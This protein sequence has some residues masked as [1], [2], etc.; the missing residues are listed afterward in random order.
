MRNNRVRAR[1]ARK[2]S[3]LKRDQARDLRRQGEPHLRPGARR[4]R[5]GRRRPTTDAVP[6]GLRAQPPRARAALHAV[7]QLLRRRRRLGRRAELGHV[8]R[9]DRLHEQ[10]LADLLL[11]LAAQGPPRA[12][13]REPLDGRAGPDRAAR[14]RRKRVPHRRRADA[15]LPLG[16]RLRQRRLV[17]QLR[18]VH[19]DPGR[20][21]GRRQHVDHDAA[22]RRALRRPRQRVLRR[23]QH[24][25]LG[26][27]AAPARVGA[28]VPRLRAALRRR[29]P[30]ATRCR[31]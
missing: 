14:L 25:L 7:R 12:R 6:R 15:R 4:P 2:P 10:D 22:G 19:D 31:G 8:G 30:S 16:Q 29:I 23:L 1:L 24:E 3:Y 5:Q 17:P 18:H 28:R 21:H 20:L 26:P 27:R 9:R 13:L 11:A